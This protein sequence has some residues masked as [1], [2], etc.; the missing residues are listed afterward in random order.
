MSRK[1]NGWTNY[2]T[3]CVNL[4]IDN[5]EASQDFWHRA[6]ER[7]KD[8]YQLAGWMR[9]HF[10]EAVPALDGFWADMP[11]AALSEVDWDEIATHMFDSV[12]EEAR[13]AV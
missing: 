8:V 6:A 3:W 10:E 7:A 9:T 4:W 13:A 2:E 1:Y 11:G 12:R 5:E